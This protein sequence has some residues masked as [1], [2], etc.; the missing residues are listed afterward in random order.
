M[1]SM[2]PEDS[3][4]ES[5]AYDD[6]EGVFDDAEG[7][8]DDAEN[9]DGE[10][11]R[12]ERRRRSARLERLQRARS[13]PAN[14]TRAAAARRQVVPTRPT[15]QQAVTAIRN[16]DA[17][18]K[19]QD[20]RFRQALAS[21][22]KDQ[23]RASYATVA[24]AVAGQVVQA[25]DQP[26]NVFARAAVLTAPLLITLKAPRRGV[27]FLGYVG[28]NP[29]LPGAVAVAA[30]TFAGNRSRTAAKVNQLVIDGPSKLEAGSNDS[31]AVEI[32]DAKGNRLTEPVAWRSANDAKASFAP[33]TS[34]LSAHQAGLVR[35]F[36]KVGE[37]EKSF[38]LEVVPAATSNQ[39]TSTTAGDSAGDGQPVPVKK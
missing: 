6:S 21:L 11:R 38:Q 4:V 31:F 1:T 8:F 33:G 12:G 26:K 17:D 30:I 36:A 14:R 39:P 3:Y 7:V 22:R 37:V 27:G 25:F 28:E 19:V 5:D 2:W 16:L 15:T 35:V 20:D 24:T 9:D 13:V 18:N 32:F 10:A 23:I 34:V 29:V